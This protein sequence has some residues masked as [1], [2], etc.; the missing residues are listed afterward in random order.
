[1]SALEIDENEPILTPSAPRIPRR[2]RYAAIAFA[3]FYTIHVLIT[4]NNMFQRGVPGP[5]GP[6]GI[7]GTIGARGEVGLRGVTG[8]T[9]A[10][11]EQGP[12]GVTGSTGAT[13]EQG[14]T[15]STGATGE[16]GPRGFNG[17]T[18]P[19]GSSG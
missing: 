11:G 14:V 2:W 9:G 6:A 19:T 17:P 3:V 12:R 8:S 18:G 1:M 15:G 5:M 16:R 13:G 7:Q 10:T 4:F